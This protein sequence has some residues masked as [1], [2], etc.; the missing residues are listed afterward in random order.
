MPEQ[1][2][3]PRKKLGRMRR[4]RK[5]GIIITAPEETAENAGKSEGQARQPQKQ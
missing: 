1:P 3:K 2:L 5:L 4:S